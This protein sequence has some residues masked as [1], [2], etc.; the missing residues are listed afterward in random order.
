MTNTARATALKYEPNEW[1]RVW[2]DKLIEHKWDIEH[3][4]LFSTQ[5]SQDSIAHTQG[6][7]DYVLN[8]G[9]LFSW[10]SAKTI[11]D[12]LQDMSRYQDPR[13]NQDTLL[14]FLCSTE[15]YT[16]LHKLGGFFK[17]NLGIGQ[18]NAGASNA[19]NQAL[20][21]IDLAVTGRKK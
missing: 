14:V 18:T 11:D 19:G 10:T 2:K 4:G 7:I 21:G 15:V 8:Y 9:N 12:F 6:A 3:A 13:Y 17:Q 20:F 5:V 1:A 16:W